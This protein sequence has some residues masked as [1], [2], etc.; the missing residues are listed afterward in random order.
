MLHKTLATLTLVG[1]AAALSGLGTFATTIEGGVPT[2][3][4]HYSVTN[5][6]Y[7]VNDAQPLVIATLA[8]DVSPAVGSAIGRVIVRV[9]V[10]DSGANR[11]IAY[12]CSTNSTGTNVSCANSSSLLTVDKLKRVTVAT[13]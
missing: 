10:A 12:L 9:D 3:D 2:A 6:S 5:V 11:S 7:S 4:L 8:F 1:V 13:Q